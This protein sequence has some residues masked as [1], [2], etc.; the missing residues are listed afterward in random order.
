MV[1]QPLTFMN[2][3]GQSVGPLARFFRVLPNELVVIHD[4]LDFEFGRIS[5]KVGGSDGGHNGLKSIRQHLGHGDFIR[6]RVGVGRPPHQWDPAD[7]VLADFSP[8]EEARLEGQA[9]SGGLLSL[10]AQA[11]LAA[12]ALGPEKAMNQFNVRP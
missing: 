2:A 10:A 6:V 7:W 1:M 8:E 11:A 9:G 4:E 5:L 12:L 3:S